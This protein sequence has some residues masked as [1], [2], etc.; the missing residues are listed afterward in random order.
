MLWQRMGQGQTET[1]VPMT[2]NE[3]DALIVEAS[4]AREGKETS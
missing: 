2:K 3:I 1:S 4:L